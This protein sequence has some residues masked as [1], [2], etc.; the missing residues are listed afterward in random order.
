M[1]NVSVYNKEG[2]EIDTLELND[3]GYSESKN[4]F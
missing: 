1:A 3:A 4:P 2:K